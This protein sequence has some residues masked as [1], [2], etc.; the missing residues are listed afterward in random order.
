MTKLIVIS[1]RSFIIVMTVALILSLMANGLVANRLER[2]YERGYQA[3]AEEH[4][5]GYKEGVQDIMNYMIDSAAPTCK[6]IAISDPK[7]SD[8]INFLDIKCL[9]ANNQKEV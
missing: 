9:K 5:S 4:N 2:N 6:S 8:E 3:G 1:R 7:L